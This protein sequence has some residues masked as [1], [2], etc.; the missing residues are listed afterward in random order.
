MGVTLKKNNSIRWLQLTALML[1]FAGGIFAHS[2][3]VRAAGTFGFAYW[4]QGYTN[5]ALFNRNWAVARPAI[6]KDAD[7]MASMSVGAVRLVFWPPVSGYIIT[8]NGG[9]RLNS[10][11]YEML[12]HLPSLI[13]IFQQ[14]KIKVMISFANSYL[15]LRNKWGGGNWQWAYGPQGF[16]KFEADSALWMTGVINA[17]GANSNI[18]F[19]DYLNEV[20][21]DPSYLL[22]GWAYVNY[23]YDHTPVPAGKRGISLCLMPEDANVLKQQLGWRTWDFIDFHSYPVPDGVGSVP[24]NANIQATY[25]QIKGLFPNATVLMGESGRQAP[26]SS[27]EAAQSITDL[28]ILNHAQNVTGLA[29][30]MNWT[31]WDWPGLQNQAFGFGYNPNSRKDVMEAVT[32]KFSQIYNAGLEIVNGTAPNQ[33]PAWW[34]ANGTVPVSFTARPQNTARGSTNRSYGHLSVTNLTAGTV[35]VVA[36][37]MNVSNKSK[38]YLNFYYRSSIPQVWVEVHEYYNDAYGNL[39]E[40]VSRS[41]IVSGSSGWSNFL[42]RSGSWSQP[43]SS[44]TTRVTVAIVGAH[45]A[46]YVE[47]LDVDTLSAYTK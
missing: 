36:P 11:Y 1:I 25:T 21:N 12:S 26:S 4:P 46:G 10:D 35:W 45:R 31:L 43:L 42:Q 20:H 9:G 16:A 33:Q 13:S 27:Y 8:Q 41:P 5:D 15:D 19:Y 30:Y 34:S 44:T 24:V 32:N 39:K 23:M 22:N 3:S 47:Y 7:Q 38:L 18:V 14:R 28:D 40:R 6:E 29:Y 37:Q 17:I 2:S